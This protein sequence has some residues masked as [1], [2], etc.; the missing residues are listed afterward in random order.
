LKGLPGSSSRRRPRRFLVPGPFTGHCEAAFPGG[1]GLESQLASLLPGY[2][3]FLNK[4]VLLKMVFEEKLIEEDDGDA[5]S[6]CRFDSG[7][8]PGPGQARGI[9]WNTGVTGKH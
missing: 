4:A 9:E 2:S 3:F 6:E 8:L 1:V 7:R 5:R